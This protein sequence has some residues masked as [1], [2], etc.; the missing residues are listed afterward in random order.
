MTLK[1]P[2]NRGHRVKR[3]AAQNGFLRGSNGQ[4]FVELQCGLRSLRAKHTH[5]QLGT[6]N[7]YELKVR[8]KIT[9]RYER[10]APRV[11]NKDSITSTL[12]VRSLR[13]Y[14]RE[15]MIEDRHWCE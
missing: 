13:V 7:G 15:R 6:G 11:L 3:E 12:R 5:I 4:K 2:K 14:E 9:S 8:R 10:R 1:E